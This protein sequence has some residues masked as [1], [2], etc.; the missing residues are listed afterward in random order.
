[1]HNSNGWRENMI[2]VFQNFIQAELE[3]IVLWNHV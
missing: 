2:K 3:V 1:M